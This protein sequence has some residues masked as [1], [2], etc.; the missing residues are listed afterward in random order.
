MDMTTPLH[1]CNKAS[2]AEF[3]GLTEQEWDMQVGGTLSDEEFDAMK[4]K[5]VND[6]K[7][8]PDKVFTFNPFEAE[9]TPTSLA[10]SSMEN[11]NSGLADIGA[12]NSHS[13]EI[14]RN[15]PFDVEEDPHVVVDN[16]E[17]DEEAVEYT[18]ADE[19]D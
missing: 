7:K 12:V 17:T 6:F 18:F 4:A 15:Y 19:L 14:E 2:S 1:W 13:H 10:A 11:D 9:D 16:Y 3:W 8:M 5:I